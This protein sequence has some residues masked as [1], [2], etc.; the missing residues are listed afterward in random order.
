MYSRPQLKTLISSEIDVYQTWLHQQL[1]L[2]NI[3]FRKQ[4]KQKKNLGD[5]TTQN[6]HQSQLI[7]SSHLLNNTHA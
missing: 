2:N 6:R 5:V 1:G 3:D 7:S 4:Q